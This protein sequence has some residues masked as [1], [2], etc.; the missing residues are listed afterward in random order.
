MDGDLRIVVRGSCLGGG[1]TRG[2]GAANRDAHQRRALARSGLPLVHLVLDQERHQDQER[3]HHDEAEARLPLD[4]ARGGLAATRPVSGLGLECGLGVGL[5]IGPECGL[6]FGFVSVSARLGVGVRGHR[7]V[8][9]TALGVAMRID[10]RS[11]ALRLGRRFGG[12]GG[13]TRFGHRSATLN[14]RFGPG[15]CRPLPR[16]RP[17]RVFGS[18]R[19]VG[20]PHG[21]PPSPADPPASGN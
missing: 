12:V 19:S 9:V 2:C 13:P 3:E 14:L 7:R 15:G 4:P 5:G 10:Q 17:P 18:R 21:R 16:P 8:P 1:L 6:R 20:D 11:D